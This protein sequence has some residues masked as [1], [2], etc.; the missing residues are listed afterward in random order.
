MRV[1]PS[2]SRRARRRLS[3]VTPTRTMFGEIPDRHWIDA[4]AS[5]LEPVTRPAQRVRGPPRLR[6]VRLCQHTVPNGGWRPLV[7][8]QWDALSHR[9]ETANPEVNLDMIHRWIAS[10]PPQLRA[11]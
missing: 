2:S 6:C 1:K 8:R 4:A 11:Q 3:I 10:W 9:S 7:P 5:D